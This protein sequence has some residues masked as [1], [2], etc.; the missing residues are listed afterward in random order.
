MKEKTKINWKKRALIGAAIIAV[1][2]AS[3]VYHISFSFQKE[4]GRHPY[5][6]KGTITYARGDTTVYKEGGGK[7]VE[8]RLKN[9]SA[10]HPLSLDG[11]IYVIEHKNIS[12]GAV[13][14]GHDQ[15]DLERITSENECY[16]ELNF[17]PQRHLLKLGGD[18]DDERAG[19]YRDNQ[20]ITGCKTKDIAFSVD[21]KIVYCIEGGKIVEYSVVSETPTEIKLGEPNELNTQSNFSEIQIIPDGPLKGKMLSL[22]G[23]NACRLYCS[24]PDGSD[25][26]C[27][28]AF[29]L[30]H[31][32]SN[33][34]VDLSGRYATYDQ[35]SS[36]QNNL[37]RIYD[38]IE[39]KYISKKDI[40]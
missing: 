2:A 23:E 18:I 6:N 28:D 4:Y 14:R 19:R 15:N 26:H 1:G 13:L 11:V 20:F 39:G 27:L 7:K 3:Y 30:P 10:R 34:R 36:E 9:G 37:I 35:I 40:K 29:R 25:M 5:I 22:R 31:Y 33:L 32:K 12:N 21:E 38:L 8:V 24:N 16:I 17:T